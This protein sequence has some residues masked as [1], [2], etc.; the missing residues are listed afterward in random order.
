[1]AANGQYLLSVKVF[2][3]H[4]ALGNT[5]KALRRKGYKELKKT[6]QE[7]SLLQKEDNKRTY[8][9]EVEGAGWYRI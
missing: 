4:C 7:K 8:F 2:F 9:K 1:M 6:K 3:N 5:L